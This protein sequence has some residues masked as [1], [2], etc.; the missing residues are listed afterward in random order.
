MMP[1]VLLKQAA[2]G[3][4]VA[5]M[6]KGKLIALPA[7][8]GAAKGHYAGSQIK[9]KQI[10]D[11]MLPGLGITKKSPHY[12]E[13]S[14]QAKDRFVYGK[15]TPVKTAGYDT[16]EPSRITHSHGP[17][18]SLRPRAEVVIYSPDGILAI[19]K[20]GYLLM[21]GGGI[22]DGETPESTVVRETMEEADAIVKNMEKLSVVDTVFDK[23]NIISEGWDGECTHFFT[24][25]YGGEAKTNHPDKENY[26]F[27]SYDDAIAFLKSLIGDP[28]QAWAKQN[29]TVRLGAI[30]SAKKKVKLP[31]ALELKKLA[32]EGEKYRRIKKKKRVYIND[33]IRRYS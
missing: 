32:E 25:L 26:K 27:I 20:N 23:D 14:Q 18:Q 19:K 16:E 1:Y 7:L 8:Y 28:A 4:P 11:K 5:Y 17:V 10:T 12:Y 21:P 30:V 15:K 33:F 6:T 3:A 22:A 9:R 31:G 13:F 2:G 29:N 24:G